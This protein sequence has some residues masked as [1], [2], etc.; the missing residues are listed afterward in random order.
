MTRTEYPHGLFVDA[1]PSGEFVLL[2]VGSHLETHFGRV[3]LPPGEAYGPMFL[4][5]SPTRDRFTGLAHD[6]VNRLWEYVFRPGWHP[7]DGPTSGRVVYDRHGN[8]RDELPAGYQYFD[9]GADQPVSR[10]VTYGPMHGLSEWAKVGALVI[11]QGHE[12]GGVLVWDGAAL[13]VLD[14]GHCTFLN[15]HADGELVAVSYVKARVGAVIVQTTL[16]ELRALPR[17]QPL[18]IN[19]PEPEPI[20]VPELQAPNEFALV[21]G[22]SVGF[23]L[24]NEARH[25]AFLDEVIRVLGGHPWGRKLKNDGVTL[26]TDVLAYDRT[27]HQIEYYDVILGDGS[28]NVSWGPTG[29]F[30]PGENG[31]WVAVDGTGSGP[32]PKPQPN[33]LIDTAL[34]E[35]VLATLVT[36][37]GVLEARIRELEARPQTPAT[38]FPTRIALKTDTGHYLC[39]EAGGGGDVNATRTAAGAW[40]TF[41]VEPQ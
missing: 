34:L 3:D 21:K 25:G 4:K 26:N 19:P 5:L 6:T 30:K 11:G 27:D 20:P 31:T 15:V 13:R 17:Y 22:V 36:D 18:I 33:V 7:I 1:L 37:Q 39:A 2:V 12:A 28:G 10:H 24:Q 41:T 14:T 23:G 32:I 35:A 40:E 16:T 29:P 38:S 9:D 8:L